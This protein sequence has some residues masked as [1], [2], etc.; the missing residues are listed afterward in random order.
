VDATERARSVSGRYDGG[1]EPA[2]PSVARLELDDLLTQLVERAQDV[3]ETQSRLRG[4]LRA[5]RAVAAELDLPAVLRR[6]IEAS[7]ELVDARYGAL[8][9]I[10]PDRHLEQFIHVGVDEETVR[11]VG[12]LPTGEGILGA[13]ISDPRPVRLADLGRDARAVGF[14]AGHPEMHTFLG[15][16]IRVRDEVFGNLYLTEKRGGRPFTAEDEELVGALAANA[17]IAIDNA[18]LFAEARHRQR[19]LEASTEITRQILA[20][21]AGS[22]TL[23]AQRAR[24]V[25]GADSASILLRRASTGGLVVEVA[26]GLDAALLAGTMMPAE[27]SIA[28]Q[29]IIQRHPVLTDDAAEE[30][31]FDVPMAREIGPMMVVPLLDRGEVDG[32][33]ALGRRRGAPP[34]S[35]SDL[36]MAAG[37]A[38][39]IALALE[40]ARAHADRDRV[41][42]LED[43]DRIA[44]DLHDRVVQ[45]LFAIA[46]GLHGLATAHGQPGVAGRMTTY[47]DDLDETIRE[48]RATIFE[49]RTRGRPP[50]GLRS[51]VLGVVDDAAGALGFRPHLRLEGALEAAIPDAV[52]DHLVAVLREALSNITRHAHATHVGVRVAVADGAAVLEVLD[53]GVGIGAP[54]RSSGLTNMR[55]RALERGGD[56]SATARPPGERGTVLRWSVPLG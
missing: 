30:A 6:I 8:G 32:A 24:E 35:E 39:H 50:G 43:R 28:G 14:P 20:S 55:D 53:D 44:R 37:F 11:R 47:V 56:F 21:G 52:A 25:A 4:L 45:R 49:L 3:M 13:L 18:R 34:F 27:T 23:I 38:G 54:A 48:I 19:W 41:L 51:V 7:R 9:V 1:S 36:D 2:F 33:L 42:L 16:P 22:L 12:H 29:A 10:G 5:N 15:V 26:D 31:G 17:G 46:L 40:L